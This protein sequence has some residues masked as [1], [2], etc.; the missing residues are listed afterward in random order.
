MVRA[1]IKL[2]VVDFEDSELREIHQLRLA[3]IDRYP[4]NRSG[5]KQHQDPALLD[6]DKLRSNEIKR[7]PG[8]DQDTDPPES[9]PEIER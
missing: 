3:E 7:T 4:R 2:N 8:S 9:A 1:D 5:H 6:N